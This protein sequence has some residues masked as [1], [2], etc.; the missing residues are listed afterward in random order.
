MVCSLRIGGLLALL[1]GDDL[2]GKE[3]RDKYRGVKRNA[4]LIKIEN[5]RVEIQEIF[6]N[7]QDLKN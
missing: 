6:L 2:L 3:S 1:H 5:L 7:Y 4:R